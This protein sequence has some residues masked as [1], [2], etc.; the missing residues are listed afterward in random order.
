MGHRVRFKCSDREVHAEHGE[1]VLAAAIRA[2][3]NVDYGCNSGN[4]GACGAYLLEGSLDRIRHGDYVQS[5]AEKADGHF[6]MCSHA[7]ASDLVLD[8]RVG[9]RAES[10]PEQ[11]FSARVRK[12]TEAGPDVRVLTL[13]MPRSRRLRFMAG[14]YALLSGAR[15]PQ[16]QCSIA[17][18]PC[19]ETRLEFHVPRARDEFSDYLFGARCMGDE[20][21]VVAPFGDF[22]FSGDFRRPVVFI[23][24]AT[25]FAPVKSLV[26]HLTGQDDEMQLSLYWATVAGKPYYDNLCRAWNDAFDGFSYTPLALGS[27]SAGAVRDCAREIAG[28]HRGLAESDV[29]ICAPE[30]FAAAVAAACSARGLDPVRLFRETMRGRSPRKVSDSHGGPDLAG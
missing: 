22:T 7:A 12:L 20:V 29:Y 21:D 23:A 15:F 19:E 18:C 6:L 9:E 24:F 28:S 8:A 14:Q 30:A 26:E 11:R 27:A 2:G 10:I 5:V 16:V 1:S 4:C 25:G 3:L 17:S 13:R